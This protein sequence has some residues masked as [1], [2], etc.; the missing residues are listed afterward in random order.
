MVVPV[1]QVVVFSFGLIITT[2]K[3]NELFKTE[4]QVCQ[5]ILIH[6]IHNY[7]FI[8]LLFLFD[9]SANHSSAPSSS[10]E[11]EESVSVDPV[12]DQQ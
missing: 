6:N 1:K 8:F 4:N 2:W 12:P 9:S 10:Y 3:I 11:V 7:I 5:Q